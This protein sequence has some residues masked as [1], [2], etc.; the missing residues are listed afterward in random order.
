MDPM[1]LYKHLYKPGMKVVFDLTENGR[2]CG[3][4]F[5]RDM[6]VRSYSEGEFNREIGFPTDAERVEIQ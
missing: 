5:E 6:T 1:E 2:N 3:F 4:K